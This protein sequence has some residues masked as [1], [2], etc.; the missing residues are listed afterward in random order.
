VKLFLWKHEYS[1][2]ASLGTARS[3]DRGRQGFPLSQ[4]WF[5]EPQA[6]LIYRYSRFDNVLISAALVQQ[7]ADAGWI[8]RLGVRAKGDFATAAGRLQPCARLNVY[9]GSS[10]SD[11]ASFISPAASTPIAS[12][13]GCTSTKLAACMTLALSTVTTLYGEV[14]HLYNS[15][16][17]ATVKSSALGSIGLRLNW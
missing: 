8:G 10:G 11:I 13:T 5:L 16:G 9:R 3:V 7:D 14:R 1:R 12:A 6:P 15:D 17:Q 4:G 2:T